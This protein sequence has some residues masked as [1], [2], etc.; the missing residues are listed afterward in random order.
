MQKEIFAK[1]DGAD[2][3]NLFNM[4]LQRLE[5]TFAVYET[6][7]SVRTPIVPRHSWLGCAVWACVLGLWFRLCPATP[8]WGVGVC[9]SS[10]VC[11]ASTPPFLAGWCVCVWVW[12]SSALPFNF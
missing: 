2:C 10:Y 5:K 11:P 9:V 12:V 3:E 6:D 8:V 4:G 7:L 1:T